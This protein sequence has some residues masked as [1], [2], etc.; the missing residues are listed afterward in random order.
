MYVTCS[1]RSVVP[2][3]VQIRI[4]NFNWFFR[5][6]NKSENDLWG[7]CVYW[8]LPILSPKTLQVWKQAPLD[9]S[10]SHQFLLHLSPECWE[11][12]DEE[13][14]LREERVLHLMGREVTGSSRFKI[15]QAVFLS[16]GKWVVVKL[17]DDKSASPASIEPCPWRRL[18]KR[19]LAWGAELPISARVLCPD[20]RAGTYW[21]VALRSSNRDPLT[22]CFP[23]LCNIGLWL[24]L[25]RSPSPSDGTNA[26]VTNHVVLINVMFGSLWFMDLYDPWVSAPFRVLWGVRCLR[27][28]SLW[29]MNKFLWC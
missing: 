21:K 26:L 15:R 5:N 18:A 8:S 7:W 6:E 14:T 20:P 24:H 4:C 29:I 17:Q 23:D 28:F 27:P 3:G 13:G 1:G 16:V 25:C 11:I 19:G 10:L 12:P 2:L 22:A 9:D